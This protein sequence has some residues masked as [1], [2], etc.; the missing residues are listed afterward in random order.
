MTENEIEVAQ[1]DSKRAR[2]RMAHD[3]LKQV[4]KIE[5]QLDKIVERIRSLRAMST[6]ITPVL[7]D[8]P[9]AGYVG[10][11][12]FEDIINRITDEENELHDE[13][14]RLLDKKDEISLLIKKVTK[15]I[16]QSVLEYHYIDFLPWET[17]AEKMNVSTGHVY[18]LRREALE[19]FANVMK[20]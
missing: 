18:R 19:A 10:N 4:S 20:R 9:K 8:M 12:R 17:V 13:M 16:Y 14:K 11:A 5:A 1:V 6:R 15:E 3:Y 2:Q 7:S